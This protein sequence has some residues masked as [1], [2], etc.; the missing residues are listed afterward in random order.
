MRLAEFIRHNRQPIIKEWESFAKT[1]ASAENMTQ[2]QLR[3]HIEPILTF[4][5]RDIESAQSP[6]QQI[7]KSHGERD[8]SEA[9]KDS[10]PAAHGNLRHDDGFDIVQMV[11]EYRALRGSVVK[12][13]T[14]TKEGL[15]D[16]D[17]VDLIRFNEA[18]DQALAESVVKFM[19]KVD[20]SKDLLLGVLGHDIR[21]PIAAMMMLG[22]LL[23]RIGSLNEKQAALTSQIGECAIR[24]NKIVG[25]L[26]DL[27]R[28]RMGTRLPVD[29]T[30]MD[31]ELVARQIV[32]EIQVLHP[33]RALILEIS[34]DVKGEWD[35]T[36]IGQLLSN[37]MSN[38]VQYGKEGSSVNV[39][40]QGSVHE[41]AISVRNE[42]EPIPATQLTTIFNSFTRG[43]LKRDADV[44]SNLG[45]GLFI[46]KE[47]VTAHGGSIDIVSNVDEEPP[48]RREFHDEWLAC[49]LFRWRSNE[50]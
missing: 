5:A 10:A 16:V 17:V 39:M 32:D 8:N 48:S 7:S 18:I 12:L 31:I 11:S 40:V 29:K 38:A 15:N 50:A 2:M 1:L 27:A 26:L 23:P 9:R 19:K 6:T 21:N 30:Q 28:A 4:I 24:V 34:G 3:D 46:A 49:V 25:D 14:K 43:D 44:G 47:I 41:V 33:N 20:Y 37:L 45:L 13:W 36:R 42:G 35:K 22:T